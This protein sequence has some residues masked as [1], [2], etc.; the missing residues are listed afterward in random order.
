MFEDDNSKVKAK[1]LETSILMFEDILDENFV[2]VLS[3][4][5]FKVF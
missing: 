3:A 5:D 4:T 1:A 2:T